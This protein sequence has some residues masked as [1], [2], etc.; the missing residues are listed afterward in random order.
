M[1]KLLLTACANT[2]DIVQLEPTIEAL[3]YKF[4]ECQI[5]L[6]VPLGYEPFF[7]HHPYV[8]AIVNDGGNVETEGYDIV[9]DLPDIS[10]WGLPIP[11][12]DKWAYAAEVELLRKTPKIF[13]DEYPVDGN[14]I[15][16]ARVTHNLREWPVF[17]ESLHHAYETKEIG[18][19]ADGD[20][21]RSKLKLMAAATLV[22]GPDSWATHAAAA[23]DARVIMAMD[24][25]D[26]TMRAPF[27]VVVSPGTEESILRAVDETLFEKRYPE[28]L[29][30]GNAAEFIKCL[31]K[32][33]M[34]SRFVDVGCSAWPIPNGIPVD[35]QNREV[36]EDAP[37]NY[38]AGLFSSH[39]LEH[40]PEWANELTLWHR[41]IR[42]GGAMV[43]YLPHPRAEVWH[44][45]TG[46]WVG[47]EHV[48]NPEPV[49]LVRFLKEVL[50]MHI[51]EYTSRRD[52]LWSFHI[53]AR[54]I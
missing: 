10:N 48:W 53:V 50:G 24:P 52:P 5:T 18:V 15:V 32:K 16:L 44:A 36:I 14:Y 1:T 30:C 43:L 39:C 3:Y 13:L 35:V 25:V 38:Y 46:S 4:E 7:E 49:S 37:D 29:N 40:V 33:Y 42:H 41:V 8:S 23:L 27:N 20:D 17:T 21:L 11:T 19:I 31:A 9:V 12:V 6:N 34:K 47:T 51:I 28:Y 45:R 2:D 54:K 22:V 26:E